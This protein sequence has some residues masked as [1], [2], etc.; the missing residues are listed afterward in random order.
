[1]LLLILQVPPPDE[2]GYV[3]HLKAESGE[4][5]VFLCPKPES[6][7]QT[8]L[9]LLSDP[10]LEDKKEML[11]PLIEDIRHQN[12][13]LSPLRTILSPYS[14]PNSHNLQVKLSPLLL[15]SLK[16]RIIVGAAQRNLTETLS[17]QP[18]AKWHKPQ[19]TVTQPTL[20]IENKTEMEKGERALIKPEN[21]KREPLGEVQ[22]SDIA[23]V[24]RLR[25]AL[26]SDSDDFAPMGGGR[27]QFQTEDQHSSGRQ[28]N[29]LLFITHIALCFNPTATK[30]LCSVH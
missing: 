19:Q 18:D 23:E 29:L 30:L 28:Q 13:M 12:S 16:K 21:I 20:S 8:P 1:M 22:H 25:N 26:I 4:I 3:I 14:P 7:P 5:E 10:L 11:R 24:C 15:N 27:F 17:S 2:N 6:P 9:S